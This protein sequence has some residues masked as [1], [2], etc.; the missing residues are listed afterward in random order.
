[1]DCIG[2]QGANK[3]AVREWQLVGGI[4]VPL[5]EVT[6]KCPQ[7]IPEDH[8]GILSYMQEQMQDVWK[9]QEGACVLQRD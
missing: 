9:A 3:A 2:D 7:Q 5:Q 4:R 8:K 1:M 6:V